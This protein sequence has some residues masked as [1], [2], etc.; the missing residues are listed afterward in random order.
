MPTTRG[1]LIAF[2]ILML[3]FAL[4]I[5]DNCTDIYLVTRTRLH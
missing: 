4:M 3:L 1:Q 5:L 2:G